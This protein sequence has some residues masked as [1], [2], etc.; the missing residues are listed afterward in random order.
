MNM[1]NQ[2]KHN[3]KAI[4]S[5]AVDAGNQVKRIVQVTK[6]KIVD[7]AGQIKQ[8]AKES[9]NTVVDTGQQIKPG[10]QLATEKMVIIGDHVK[11]VSKRTA[12]KV[13]DVSRETFH[14]I[15][16]LTEPNLKKFR[17]EVIDASKKYTDTATNIIN[18]T[19]QKLGKSAELIDPDRRSRDVLKNAAIA[20]GSATVGAYAKILAAS[21]SFAELP[22]TLKAKMVLAGLGGEKGFRSVSAAESFYE[23][24]IPDVV[25]NFGEEAV[26]D[27]WE[28]KHASH[29]KSVHNDPSLA[30][31]DSNIVWEAAEKNQVRGSSDM[32][33]SELADANIANLVDAAGSVAAEAIEIAALAGCFG[34]ALEGIV[35]LGENMIY[36]YAGERT[37]KEAALDMAKNMGKKGAL[38]S[39]SGVVISVAIAC[40]AGPVLSSMAPVFVTIGGTIYVIGTV[41]RISGAYKKTRP[42]LAISMR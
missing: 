2:I 36:V 10:T 7:T 28:G 4:A 24:S 19:N 26:V 27:F 21:P 14:K 37:A 6:N 3:V 29:I 34:I 11:K 23:S 12:D 13:F 40:G 35:S 16:V 33:G 32:T 38:S 42:E 5:T 9:A 20:M 30:M 22:Q 15:E 8:V 25:K 18:L 39:V 31:R 1:G 17:Q 41:N